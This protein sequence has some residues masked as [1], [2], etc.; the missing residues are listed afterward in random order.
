MGFLTDITDGIGLTDS[1][2]GSRAMERQAAAMEEANKF[3]RQAYEEGK[4]RLNPYATAGNQ[5]FS[6]L[7]NM[8]NNYQNFSDAEGP[9]K[10]HSGVFTMADFKQDPG[11]Q[12]RMQEGQKAIDRSAAAR[13]MNQSGATLKAMARFGQNL[14]SSE[15]NNAYN[16]FNQDYSNSYNRFNSDQDRKFNR[17]GNIANMGL[18]ANQSMNGLSTNFGNSMANNAM[19]LGNA[20]A[21]YE[22]NKGNTMK[23][24]WEMGG[25]AFGT[26]ATGG[27]GG[28]KLLDSPARACW[29]ARAIF[30]D[31]N[32][33][34]L[35]ARNYV[36][37]I[38]PKWFRKLYLKHGE[39]F[40]HKVKKSKALKLA[41]TPLFEYFAWRGKEK[42]SLK[43]RE[44]AH[45]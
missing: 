22:M 6:D 28:G 39:S 9:F 27:F 20:Q 21:S 19:A 45:A 33:K 5:S 11:Y 14:G 37:N 32:P 4:E 13:G 30:G 24:L 43:T 17:V 36:L 8:T 38:G 1:G 18:S 25:Q 44:V 16:R 12:F 42:Q 23:D 35:D 3:Q 34:W 2:A 41:L 31:K 7:V 15:Y 10:G 40:S 26:F 29:V